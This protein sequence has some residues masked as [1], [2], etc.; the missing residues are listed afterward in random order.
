MSESSNR[1]GNTKRFDGA[2]PNA[3]SQPV[4]TQNR[5]AP[6]RIAPPS[7]V[8]RGPRTTTARLDGMGGGSEKTKSARA[9]TVRLGTPGAPQLRHG[10]LVV[11]HEWFQMELKSRA[12]AASAGAERAAGA[13]Q[14][15]GAAGAAG[16]VGAEQ[17]AGAAQVAHAERAGGAEQMARA[18]RAGGAGEER[19]R[20]RDLRADPQRGSRSKTGLRWLLVAILVLVAGAVAVMV[21]VAG[22]GVHARGA[23]A[24]GVPTAVPLARDE[25]RQLPQP[26]EVIPVEPAL[27]PAIP[28]AASRPP[29]P[30]RKTW[31]AVAAPTAR[32]SALVPAASTPVQLET[33]SSAPSAPAPP[34]DSPIPIIRPKGARRTA[35]DP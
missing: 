23:A 18:E 19:T 7:E 32:G 34:A 26:P 4:A 3:G 30:V 24:E 21:G 20:D 13:E 29:P 15:V 27:E 5:P 12:E 35:N 9:E 16:A 17:A 2:P 14:A 31:A 1:T 28:S 6:I 10:E 8:G 22:A 33:S 25:Q 11:P